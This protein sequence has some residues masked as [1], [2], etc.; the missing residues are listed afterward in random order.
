MLSMPTRDKPALKQTEKKKKKEN[1][2]LVILHLHLNNAKK[3]I[4]HQNM[5]VLK[6]FQLKKIMGD[7]IYKFSLDNSFRIKMRKKEHQTEK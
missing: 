6:S 7:L 4:Y 5:A 2:T 1:E 3:E